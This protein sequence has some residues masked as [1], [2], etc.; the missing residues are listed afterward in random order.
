M[1]DLSWWLNPNQ[2]EL[3]V[4]RKFIIFKRQ[5]KRDNHDINLKFQSSGTEVVSAYKFLVRFEENLSWPPHINKIH[6]STP[7]LIG[8]LIN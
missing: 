2:L 3:N 7:E 8:I 1:I 5:G 4:K 6:A